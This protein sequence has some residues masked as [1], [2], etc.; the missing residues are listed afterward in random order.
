MVILITGVR[1]HSQP[2]S[3]AC[4][5]ARHWGCQASY[6]KASGSLFSIQL[7]ASVTEKLTCFSCVQSNILLYRHVV[8]RVSIV[9]RHA[10]FLNPHDVL[11]LAL[12]QN[13][14]I[15]I[16]LDGSGIS[17]CLGAGKVAAALGIPEAIV[18]S[19]VRIR[20]HVE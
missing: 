10:Y 7:Q 12:Q 5:V 15:A 2:A 13:G 4:T 8:Q 14:L 17:R 20:A 1:G 18:L 9:V 3:P 19:F 16:V 6:L 11:S